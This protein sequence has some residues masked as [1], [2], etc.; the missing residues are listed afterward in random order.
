M[1]IGVV[2]NVFCDVMN[3]EVCG[4]LILFFISCVMSSENL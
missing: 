1:F 3:D 4:I 2:V